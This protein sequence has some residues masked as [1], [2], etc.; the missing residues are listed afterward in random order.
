MIMRKKSL[1]VLIFCCWQF[2]LG[3]NIDSLQQTIDSADSQIGKA[4]ALYAAAKEMKK[5]NPKVGFRWLAECWEIVESID[6][7]LLTGRIYKLEGDLFLNSGKEDSATLRYR[8]AVPFLTKKEDEFDLMMIYMWLG[9]IAAKQ[10]SAEIAIDLRK[11]AL[12]LGKNIGEHRGVKKNL[13]DIGAAFGDMENY[14]SSL[15]YLNKAIDW[16]IEAGFEDSV[17]LAEVWEKMGIVHFF[18]GDPATSLSYQKKS[19]P[20]FVHANN[21]Q[22]TT[23]VLI[24]VGNVYMETG[25]LDSAKLYFE[26]AI[27]MAEKAGM[28]DAILVL[29]SNT[30]AMYE[31]EGDFQKALEKFLQAEQLLQKLPQEDLETKRFQTIILNNIGNVYLSLNNIRKAEEYLKKSHELAE[32]LEKNE[33]ISDSHKGLSNFYRDI[34]NF[35]KAYDHLNQHIIFNEEAFSAEKRA[36]IEELEAQFQTARKEK[37]IA[38]LEVEKAQKEAETVRKNQQIYLLFG[39]IL[40]LLMGGGFVFYYLS[41]KQRREKAEAQRSLEKREAQIQE[42]VQSQALKSIDAM[43]EGQENERARIARDLHDRLGSTMSMIKLHF[44]EFIDQLQEIQEVNRSNF[45]VVNDLVDEAV[46]EVRRISHNMAAGTLMEFGLVP[47]IFELKSTIETS[48]RIKL[49]VHIFNLDFRLKTSDEINLYRI[50]QELINNTLKHAQASVIE[51]NLTRREKVLSVLYDDNGVGMNQ[52]QVKEGMGLKN[53]QSRVE[54][55]NGK[56]HI[57]SKP[58][59]GVHYDIEV[60]IEGL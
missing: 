22:K 17:L 12:K 3:T 21:H 24:G 55:L 43:I 56:I 34:G 36:R 50:I 29:T 33:L 57:D 48:Q 10:D 5:E 60:P 19:L 8:K 1:F 6:Y 2:S 15:Y 38:K 16:E 7:E 41:Q 30:G 25:E 44:S 28:N 13:V 49:D 9:D 53:I 27:P 58:G 37:E 39:I 11:K 4:E 51:I 20:H 54:K 52:N 59:R 14:D 47:A 26:K 46:N 23:K 40:I 42:L 18:M 31:R 45:L 32:A 35:E